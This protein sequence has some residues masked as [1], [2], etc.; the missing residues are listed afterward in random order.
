MRLQR[1]ARVYR[2]SVRLTG[3][4]SE[5]SKKHDVDSQNERLWNHLGALAATHFRAD[6]SGVHFL[7]PLF[8]AGFLCGFECPRRFARVAKCSPP[9]SNKV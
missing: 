1:A 2:I 7:C 6:P 3:H 4:A 5:N 9:I 8:D